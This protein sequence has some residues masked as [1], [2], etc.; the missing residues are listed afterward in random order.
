VK[1]KKKPTQKILDF[2][3]FFSFVF[4]ES[5][6]NSIFLAALVGA[7]AAL[8]APPTARC[9]RCLTVAS[10]PT[11]VPIEACAAK[12]AALSTGLAA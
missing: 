5:M 6:K 7:G 9:Q 1:R 3:F 12:C 2:F 8:A 10:I 11:S 4:L